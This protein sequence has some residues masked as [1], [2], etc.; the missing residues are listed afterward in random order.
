MRP[1]VILLTGLLL[2]PAAVGTAQAQGAGAPPSSAC[3]TWYKPDGGVDSAPDYMRGS[4]QD[5]VPDTAI[6]TQRPRTTAPS[7][8]PSSEQQ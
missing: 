6:P 8:A 4:V 1:A 3:P 2:I 7:A 5:L